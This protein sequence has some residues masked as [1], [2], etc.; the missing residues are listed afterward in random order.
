[1]I[2]ARWLRFVPAS[3]G[4]L[5]SRSLPEIVMTRLLCC[6][7][8]LLFTF[9]ARAEPP[10]QLPPGPPSFEE[11]ATALHLTDAQR[12]PVKAIMDA[13]HE[14]MRALHQATR[15]E[16]DALRDATEAKLANLL[17]DE[18]MQWLQAFHA[19]H[20]PPPPADGA[21]GAGAPPPRS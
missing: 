21:A 5:E 3:C 18:Q 2:P 7:I 17:S 20:R 16:R 13:Q 8:V 19:A 6:L 10:H 1:M 11:F 14:Q 9:A 12:G 15:E 4:S